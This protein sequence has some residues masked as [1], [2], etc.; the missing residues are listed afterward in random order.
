[1]DKVVV[2]FK[3]LASRYAAEDRAD[4][5]AKG[6]QVITSVVELGHNIFTRI[7]KLSGI[8]LL[9]LSRAPTD[10]IDVDD[11]NLLHVICDYASELSLTPLTFGSATGRMYRCGALEGGTISVISSS[12]GWSN[13]K[14]PEI[15]SVPMKQRCLSESPVVEVVGLS[16]AWPLGCQCNADPRCTEWYQSLANSTTTNFVSRVLI[17]ES[18][19]PMMNVAGPILNFSTTPARLLGVLD[20]PATLSGMNYLV[21]SAVGSLLN[22][23]Y[24][25]MLLNDTN[26]TTLA[27]VVRGCAANETPPGNS[28][29][30]VWSSLRSCD[31]GLR[32]VAQWLST[33]QTVTQPLEL[34]FVG[35]SWDIY[36]VQL[37][38]FS[39]FFILSSNL[40]QINQPID[41][42]EAKATAQ[43][44]AAR[45]EL[46]T[47]ATNSGNATWRYVSA[48]GA[49]NIAVIEAL[50][51]AFLAQIQAVENSSLATLAAFQKL[52]SVNGEHLNQSLIEQVS[53]LKNNSLDAMA[54]TT[55]WIIAV[56]FA[57]LL[58]VLAFSA[59]G[60]IR[61]T[62]HLIHIIG[63]MEDVAEMKVDNLEVPQCSGVTEVARIQSAFQVL[64]RRLA[65]YKSYI[66]AGL[67]EKGEQEMALRDEDQDE[68]SPKSSNCLSSEMEAV[69]VGR[70]PSCAT[71]SP[72]PSPSRRSF[73]RNVAVMSVNLMGF[74]DV[75]LTVSDAISKN[76]FN[77]YVTLVHE[78]V[79][80]NRG[81]I[82]CLLG[83][84]IFVTFN[85]HIPC[86]DPAGA[87]ATAA[88]E[89]QY[90]LLYHLGDRL[91]FQ[92]GLSFGP[93][94]ASSVGY[95]KFKSMVTMGSPLQLA[96]MLSRIPRFD[97]GK[98]LADTS[99][100]ERVKYSFNL[101]PV[102]LLYLPHLKSFS[103]CNPKSQRI[104]LL[105]SKKLLQEDEW[106]YQVQERTSDWV[107]T[108]D[109]L[110]AAKSTQ[111]GQTLLH[112]FLADHPQDEVALR[113]RDR[114]PM[115]SP[116][117][118]IAP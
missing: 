67:F 63:L 107:Q 14:W 100:D 4:L 24:M 114:L 69:S 29:L 98:I 1:M 84:Q 16:C 71:S 82:D 72:N 80:Q 102:E 117:L 75:L 55:G 10:P 106:L 103:K 54:I 20:W 110:V 88:L 96:A 43:L 15:T 62:N 12:N 42:S 104:S 81:N 41:I 111:E 112:Q 39:Y 83:D 108:F 59:W 47:Q 3:G 19:T 5:A 56:V 49:E 64:V 38:S 94:F 28:S 8:G 52:R 92:I 23:N 79:A 85:A 73:K 21:T 66:P 109:R 76:I 22:G 115:W 46:I 33:N 95:T 78:A 2:D 99:F 105:L 36:P 60:T 65:E 74:M 53:L 101:R 87:A 113:L 97:N 57:I 6:S 18:G 30:P 91:R 50:Q 32:A 11:C 58:L 61:V 48:V 7:Q 34:E 37:L 89:V 118:G 31:P 86:A 116:G 27:S 40:T 93:T 77:E 51:D 90:Q 68:G 13:W 26:L 35:L 44:S 17:D 25:A 9:N 45:T 70:A